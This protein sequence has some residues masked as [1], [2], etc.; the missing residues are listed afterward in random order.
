MREK[1]AVGG[2]D[3]MSAGRGILIVE[4]NIDLLEL[5]AIML[6]NGCEVMTATSGEEAIVVYGERRPD[7]VVMDIVLPGMDGIE[8]AREILKID[9]KAKI[10]GVTA[11]Y[12][13]KSRHMLEAGALEVLKKPFTMQEL[14]SA[15]KR[16]LRDHDA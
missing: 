13:S 15:V 10:I 11:Y 14:V 6:S 1:G 16:Y 9:P 4:D 5:M 2:D 12:T 8:V 3:H 7:V